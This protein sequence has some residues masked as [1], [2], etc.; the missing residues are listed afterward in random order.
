MAEDSHDI[1]LRTLDFPQIKMQLADLTLSETGRRMALSIRPST[2]K[3]D[4]TTW[5][6]ETADGL[7][8]LNR[9]NGMPIASFADIGHHIKRLEIDA[10]LNGAEL[11]DIRRILGI[12]NDVI[13]FFVAVTE[14]PDISLLTLDERSQTFLPLDKLCR[15]ID[16]TIDQAGEVLD[17]AS[18]SLKR[19][20]SNIES[21]QHAIRQNL[22]KFVSGSGSRYLSDNLITMRNDRYVIPV[23]AESKGNVPG[24]VHDQSASGQT[25]FI[26]PQNVVNLNN[27]ITSLQ[28]AEKEEVAR[29]LA[30]LSS[31]L[32]G[33]TNE[34]RYDFRLLTQFDFIQAKARL[35]RKMKASRPEISTDNQLAF[36]QA[37]HP[38]IDPKQVVANDLIIGEDY[39]IIIVTGPNTGGKTVVLK[40]L[41][42]LQIMGQAGLHLPV[43]D[44]SKMAIFDHIFADIGDEQSIEQNLSTFSSHMTNIIH[45]MDRMT[46]K[47]LLLFDELGAGTDPQEG[48]ALAIAILERISK[49]HTTAVI[50]SH[51]PELKAYG[52]NKDNIINASMTF[53]IDTLSPSYIL[54]LGIPGRSNAF[55]IASRLG[56]PDDIIRRS[57][58]LMTGE[59]Q[60]VDTMI[61]NLETQR[62]ESQDEYE[63]LADN[64]REAMTIRRQLEQAYRDF[65][66]ERDNM[67]AEAKEAADKKIQKKQEQADKIIQDL[68]QRQLEMGNN[69]NVKEHELIDAQTRLDRLR[70]QEEKEQLASNKYVK[71]ASKDDEFHIGDEVNVPMLNQHGSLV[72][73]LNND[74]WIVQL[75]AMKMKVHKDKM[76]LLQSQQAEPTEKRQ[77]HNAA[78]KPRVTTELDLRGLHYEE[79]MDHLAKYIDAALL[80]NYEMVTI[81]HGHGTG[82]LRKG[83]QERLKS[84]PQVASFEYAPAN[85]GGTGATLVKFKA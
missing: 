5:Q 33:Y 68:R 21:A 75:G 19:I 74:E 57:R 73:E 67:L 40:T 18:P 78:V 81:I 15:E 22:N 70:S 49:A 76:E 37:R 66:A 27:Q 65:V 51:Y 6:N 11:V 31:H 85:Q 62:Q 35:A 50:T 4:I 46:D 12:V 58:E 17:S 7:T 43:A 32:A 24:V 47:S 1:N 45:I 29:I 26:E 79:A 9:K 82:A 71:Q 54:Q 55:E 61:A 25:L 60:S 53:D 20:R 38:L 16:F 3:E 8:L 72:E 34:I 41:G 14:D 36:Y 52:Y 59:S 23:K 42:L 48:A 30:D 10:G 80:N 56:M 63:Y 64:L 39:N 84:I 2:D 69:G 28:V 83:V 13:D 77:R 44:H